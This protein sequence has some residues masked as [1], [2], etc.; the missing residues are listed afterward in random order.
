MKMHAQTPM[1][2]KIWTIMYENL[3]KLLCLKMYENYCMRMYAEFFVW[4]GSL[5]TFYFKVE[6]LAPSRQLSSETCITTHI[7]LTY[8]RHFLAYQHS[9]KINNS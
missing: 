7:N 1:F 8:C 5:W 9:L 3:C 2:S 4:Q 6:L